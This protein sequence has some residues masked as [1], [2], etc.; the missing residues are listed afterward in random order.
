MQL[1]WTSISCL[2]SPTTRITASVLSN[3]ISML[4]G[5]SGV[6]AVSFGMRGVMLKAGVR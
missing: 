6:V 4:L 2:S 1:A 3:R 5:C